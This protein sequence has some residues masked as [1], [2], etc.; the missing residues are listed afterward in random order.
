MIWLDPRVR[1][2]LAGR[3]PWYAGRRSLRVSMLSNVLGFE[4]FLLRGAAAERRSFQGSSMRLRRKGCQ[5]NR[6]QP[7]RS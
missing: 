4:T 1:A 7:L 5:P 6:F 2:G 3:Q